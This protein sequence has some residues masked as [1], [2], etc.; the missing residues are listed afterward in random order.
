MSASRTNPDWLRD[1]SDTN[2]LELSWEVFGELCRALAVKVAQ[3]GYQPDL[4]IGIAKAGVIPGAVTASI[5]QTDF[6]SMK[7][8]RDAGVER[9]RQ[10]PKIFSAAP[11]EATGRKV[12]IVDEICSSGDTLRLAI[13]A[14]RAVGPEEIRTAVSFV[15]TAGFQPDYHALQTDAT[16]IFPWDRQIVDESGELLVNPE[17][18][19]L[20]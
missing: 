9:V 10:R 15:R 16:I 1:G 6:F 7:I 17:Y 4:V 11:R 14:L 19:E 2:V 18:S 20:I 3:S 13:N 5:L 12:L 8:S